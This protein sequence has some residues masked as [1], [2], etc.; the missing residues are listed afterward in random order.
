[1]AEAARLKT[2]HANRAKSEFLSNMSHDIR[3][4]MNAIV[5]M[6]A[7]ATANLDNIDQVQ[8]C[9]KKITLSSKHLLGLIN[10]VLDM[11]KIESGKMT[12]NT[13]QVSLREVVD[14]IVSI[15]QPQVKSKRQH[16]LAAGRD[17]TGLHILVAE[18]NEQNW[19]I[20]SEL[21]SEEGLV[22]KWAENGQI[23]MEK[24]QASPVGFYDAVLMDVR[25]PIM[26]G[27]EATQVIRDLD[28]GMNAH[29]AKPIDVREVI[30]LLEKF[31]K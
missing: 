5:G 11:S 6:T 14:S 7:I 23:C 9:L 26:G 22:L 30:R 20:T 18:D 1:M 21:L 13:D 31:I 17:F 16:F 28:C 27:C 24:F 10:D 29:V 19:E 4:P 12:L 25:M 15:C 3:T 2:E 8:H